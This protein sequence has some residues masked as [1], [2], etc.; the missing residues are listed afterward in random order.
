MRRSI[1]AARPW[2][3]DLKSDSRSRLAAHKYPEA[4][5]ADHLGHSTKFKEFTFEDVLGRSRNR[6][7]NVLTWY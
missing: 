4:E 5:A 7:L 2:K 3:A 1:E 6:L